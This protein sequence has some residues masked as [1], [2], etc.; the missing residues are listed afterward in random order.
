MFKFTVYRKVNM[1]RNFFLLIFVVLLVLVSVKIIMAHEKIAAYNKA[2][3]LFESGELVA[4]EE[5]FH[6]AKLNVAVTDHNT[7][8]NRMLSILSPIRE[9]MEDLDGK[10]AD[11]NEENDL[12]NL[13]E[14]YERWQESQEKWVSGTSVQ[15]D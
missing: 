14:T 2:V 6:A 11:Y 1:S 4:A 8:I 10:A 12:D 15:K 5:K 9:I 7:D 3:K 13:V